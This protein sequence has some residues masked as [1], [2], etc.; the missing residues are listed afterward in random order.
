MELIDGY[1]YLST[2][3]GLVVVDIKRKE[4]KDTYNREVDTRSV[5]RYGDYWYAITMTGVKKASISTNLSDPNNWKVAEE[6]PQ[7]FQSAKKILVFKDRFCFMIWDHAYYLDDNGGAVS[8]SE[9]SARQMTVLNGQLILVTTEDISFYLDLQNKIQIPANVYFVDCR[10]SKNQYWL[11]AGNDGLTVIKKQAD[12]SDFTTDISGIKINSPKR[13]LNF[14]MTCAGNKLLIVGGSRDA[15]RL[16]IPGTLMVYEN[17]KWFNF[18][19]D[20]IAKK[21]GLPCLDFM[22]VAVD[23]RDPNHYFVASW[24]EGLYEFRNNEFVYLHTE[25]NSALQSAVL[26]SDRYI[27]VDGLAY[28]KDNNLYM[29]NAGGIVRNTLVALSNQNEWESFFV[30]NFIGAQANK[31]MIS[32]SGQKWMNIWRLASAGIVVVDKNNELL[33]SSSVFKDQSGREFNATYYLDIVEDMNGTIWVATD[34]GPI[35]FSSADQ[36]ANKVCTRIILSDE[37]EDGFYP[38]DGLRVTSIAVDGANRKWFGT[39]NS[40]VFVMDQ[41][42]GSIRIDNYNT[43]NSYILSNNVNSIAVNQETGEVFIGTDMGLCSYMGEA[44]AGKAD[45]SNVYAYPN[46][47]KPAS[48]SRVVITGLVQN[49]TVKITDMAGN[50]IKEGTSLG[51]QYIWNCTDRHDAIVKAG[52]YLVFASTSDGIQGVVTK[53]M[54]IK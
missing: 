39:D 41:S 5:C 25:S 42:E 50:L 47:V 49:S 10:N 28:D 51:G 31:I 12:P 17:G 11:A 44:I 54:V 48:D 14:Y 46:P 22:S 29:V 15:N 38:L 3:F 21:T 26:G 32:K 7:Y 52:I 37:R 6:I 13:N 30:E 34:N 23:P 43:D 33:A 35:S 53:I 36:V 40:G 19:E 1:A 27:R 20:T 9:H 2:A 45:Y 18:D 16:D 24:G 4:I 8:L